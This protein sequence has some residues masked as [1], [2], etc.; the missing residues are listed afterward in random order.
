MLT[1]LE[2]GRWTWIYSTFPIKKSFKAGFYL[3]E[4]LKCK[5]TSTYFLLHCLKT[6]AG[7]NS[8]S[9]AKSSTLHIL[10]VEHRCQYMCEWMQIC[11]PACLT[12]RL[13]LRVWFVCNPCKLCTWVILASVGFISSKLILN[14]THPNTQK[15]P[16]S[17]KQKF[18]MSPE[19]LKINVTS[20]PEDN[21]FTG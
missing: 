12:P 13:C 8:I 1:T 19:Q 18:P 10:V 11:C 20:A 6:K 4:Y 7:T 21:V 17:R 16:K 14:N 9:C 3:C 2:Y 5:Y 15:A